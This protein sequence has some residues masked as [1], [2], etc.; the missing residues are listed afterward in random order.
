MF[1]VEHVG[2]KSILFAGA[3]VGALALFHPTRPAVAHLTLHATDA[4]AEPGH[5]INYLTA[6]HDHELYLDGLSTDHLVPF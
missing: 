1:A 3:A 5:V 6:F 4:K 2:L